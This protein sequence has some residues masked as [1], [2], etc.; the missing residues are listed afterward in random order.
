MRHPRARS[1][2]AWL[3]LC[4][5]LTIWGVAGA[6]WALVEGFSK[7]GV[8]WKQSCSMQPC[9]MPLAAPA[10]S[11]AAPSS[12]ADSRM[13]SVRWLGNTAAGFSGLV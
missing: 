11:L 4:G 3:L 9:D 12:S 8:K 13:Y 1:C 5:L 6:M 10:V 2:V 7:P